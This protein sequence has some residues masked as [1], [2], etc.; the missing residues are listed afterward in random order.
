MFVRINLRAV[1]DFFLNYEY[2][3]A[4]FNVVLRFNYWVNMLQIIYI[5]RRLQSR[6]C[7]AE[8]WIKVV[9]C[10][11]W[12]LIHWKLVMLNETHKTFWKVSVFVQKIWSTNDTKLQQLKV[13]KLGF[14]T[15]ELRLLKLIMFTVIFSRF[16][17]VVELDQSS[18][19]SKFNI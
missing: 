14:M 1:T 5:L 19:Y 13:R 16:F 17:Y 6:L 10:G 15:G 11:K 8:C 2:C 3:T 4:K 18:K 12:N 9:K 7:I